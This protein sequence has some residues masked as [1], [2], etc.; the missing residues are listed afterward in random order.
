MCLEY[1]VRMKQVCTFTVS[2]AVDICIL[3]FVYFSFKGKLEKVDGTV[4]GQINE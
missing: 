1:K 4:H 2:K 3:S